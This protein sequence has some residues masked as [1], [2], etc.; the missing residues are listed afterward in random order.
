MPSL[1]PH[2]V[3]KVLSSAGARTGFLLTMLGEASGRTARDVLAQHRLKPRQLRILDLL[4]DRGAIGQR[5]LG[6]VMAIDHS[7]LVNLLNPMEADRL[8]KRERDASDRRRHLVT[9]TPA[10]TRRLAE[11]DRAFCDAEDAF[12]APLTEEQRDQ[13][14]DLLLALRDANPAPDG[15]DC[16]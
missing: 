12:F 15:D 7:I 5:E 1:G 11:A 6:E 2:Q 16:D 4:A 14:H 8:V 9:I 13:L 3:G 10:G